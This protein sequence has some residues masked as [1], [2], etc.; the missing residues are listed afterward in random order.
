[1]MWEDEVKKAER[2]RERPKLKCPAMLRVQDG[3]F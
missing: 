1:M 2:E 3:T